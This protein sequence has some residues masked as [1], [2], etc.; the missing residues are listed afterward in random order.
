[1]EKNIVSP[2]MSLNKED[3]KRI[4]TQILAIY[5][6]VIILFLDQL[7]NWTFDYK[8]LVALAVSTTFDIVRR[9]V[10]EIKK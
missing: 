9:Y 7:Q 3:Y 4:A 8:I 5:S 1:M 10:R 6:P 2:A